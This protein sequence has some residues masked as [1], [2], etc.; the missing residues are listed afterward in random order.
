MARLDDRCTFVDR[1]QSSGVAASTELRALVDC[2]F[3]LCSDSE[4]LAWA[5]LS[6]FAGGFDLAAAERVCSDEMIPSKAHQPG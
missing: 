1:G 5:R 6:V 3:D 4:R 2:S